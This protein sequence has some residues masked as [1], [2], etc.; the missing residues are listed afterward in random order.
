M[1]ALSSPEVPISS[2]V[3]SQYLGVILGTVMCFS[4][5]IQACCYS[6]CS[7]YPTASIFIAAP[8]SGKQFHHNFWLLVFLPWLSTWRTAASQGAVPTCSL[9]IIILLASFAYLA[10]SRSSLLHK[11][12]FSCESLVLSSCISPASREIISCEW[13][14]TVCTSL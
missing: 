2:V 1:K 7:F 11:C 8:L 9:W 4:L 10:P 14:S 12:D 13:D 3:F 5:W 6:S